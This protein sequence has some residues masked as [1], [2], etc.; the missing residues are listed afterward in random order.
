M[1]NVLGR[2]CAAA[3]LLGGPVERFEDVTGD[4]LPDMVTLSADG[5]LAVSVNVGGRQFVP[6]GEPFSVGQG[7]SLL[8]A[9]LDGD[10]LLDLLVVADGPNHA[11][12]GDGAGRF[13]DATE[14]LGLADAGVGL[15]AE[16][17]D[18]DGDGLDDV[19]LRNRDG[20]VA[21][22]NNGGSYQ[23]HAAVGDAA[24]APPAWTASPAAGPVLAP[25]IA[26]PGSSP[27]VI[28]GRRV[29]V[30]RPNSAAASLPLGIFDDRYV[31]DDAGEVGSADIIDGSLT[32]PDISTA[33]G[34]VTILGGRLGLGTQTPQSQLDIAGDVSVG[35]AVVIDQ[36]GAWIGD[37][38]SFLPVSY[39]DL[40]MLGDWSGILSDFLAT[41]GA[42]KGPYL[43]GTQ[44]EAEGAPA[45][46]TGSTSWVKLATYGPMPRSGNL[47]ASWTMWR[48]SSQVSVVEAQVRTNGVPVGQVHSTTVDSTQ[49]GI[50]VL[51]T[52]PV[53]AGDT[54][55]VWGRVDQAGAGMAVLN[56]R[57]FCAA[58]TEQTYNDFHDA[59]DAA[60]AEYVG[61]QPPQP[62][63]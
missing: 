63:P 62:N 53:M 23:R 40:Q 33:T 61:L 34:D 60:F 46:S 55:E 36:T 39:S 44:M 8:V 49:G 17:R 21:F 48:Q 56:Y 12:V 1:W 32:G 5:Q 18:L 27:L 50:N 57:L 59:V 11:L 6:V 29:R 54:V 43:P 47:D 9:D 13:V 51:E 28:D 58:A 16:L 20:D 26:P 37:T 10:R 42:A 14:L 38:S 45:A 19:L 52:I 4:G 35:G 15:S 25:A 41:L 22:W 3:L 31:N 2:V 7:T 24:G 30:P